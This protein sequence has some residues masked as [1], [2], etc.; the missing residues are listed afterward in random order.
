MTLPHFQ[1]HLWQTC[2]VHLKP[3]TAPAEVPGYSLREATALVR[4]YAK[5]LATLTTLGTVAQLLQK[6][7]QHSFQGEP[8]RRPCNSI[9]HNISI[10]SAHWGAVS[11][12]RCG[13]SALHRPHLGLL[14]RFHTLSIPS[15]FFGRNH[16][17]NGHL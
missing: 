9:T 16:L 6:L 8:L 1:G 7:S 13:F 5:Y 14:H 17:I 10:S 4:A 12:C 15:L 3:D 11:F 2:I